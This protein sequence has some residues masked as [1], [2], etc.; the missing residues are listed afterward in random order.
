MDPPLPAK[1]RYH[2][3][4]YLKSFRATNFHFLYKPSIISTSPALPTWKGRF[5]LLTLANSCV[6]TFFRRLWADKMN[7]KRLIEI[8]TIS[9]NAPAPDM[10]YI[11]IFGAVVPPTGGFWVP[12]SVVFKIPCNILSVVGISD[13]LTVTLL[14][15][16][17]K[18]EISMES[19]VKI[20]IANWF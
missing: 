9:A 5:L 8:A 14:N 7:N 12:A 20:D 11:I 10:I 3:R 19:Q 2:P 6:F 4:E 15:Q 13:T 16:T 17:Y 1:H 18:F